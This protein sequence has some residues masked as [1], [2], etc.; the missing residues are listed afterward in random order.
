MATLESLA[1]ETPIIVNMTGG[2]QEQ[3]TNGV[4]WFGF[5]IEPVSSAVIGTQKIPYIYEE[6]IAKKDFLSAMNSMMTITE[7]E[8]KKMIQGGLNH[9]Q[10][11]YSFEKYVESWVNLLEDDH[12]RYGSWNTREGYKRWH[13]LEAA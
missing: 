8:K 12:Q 13:L 10:E 5:G 7:E 3:I 2:L 9:V 6:R 1:C 4:D 11:N